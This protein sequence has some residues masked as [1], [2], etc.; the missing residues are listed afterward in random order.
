MIEVDEQFDV[1]APPGAIWQLLADPHAVVGCVP[2]A[3]IVGQ[4]ENGSF[5]MTL[6]VKFGPLNIAFQ[7]RA[8]LELD[9]DQMHGRLSARG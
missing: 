9:T 3:A 2:G 8:E 7:A 6:T 5:D 1:P 4:D